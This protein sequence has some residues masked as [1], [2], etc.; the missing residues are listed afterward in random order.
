MYNTNVTQ[1]YIFRLY[2]TIRIWIWTILFIFSTGQCAC[3]EDLIS[4]SFPSAIKHNNVQWI[5]AWLTN[6]NNN[7]NQT[8]LDGNTVLHW[9][10]ESGHVEIV[11]ILLDAPELNVNAQNKDGKTPLHIAIQDS[12]STIKVINQT[13]HNYFKEV[14]DDYDIPYMKVIQELLRH[15]DI[16]VN[17]KDKD[18]NTPLHMSVQNNHRLYR[19]YYIEDYIKV[20]EGLLKHK[21]INVNEK[22]KNGNTPLHIAVETGNTAVIQVLIN[23]KKADVNKKNTNGDTAL[24]MTAEK[25]HGQDRRPDIVKALCKDPNIRIDERNQYGYTASDI[26]RKIGDTYMADLLQEKPIRG[27]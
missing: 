7:V 9:A 25:W 14:E 5:K 23:S 11:K 1:R 12:I 13:K 16:N 3:E 6:P 21:D 8:Y 20:I 22:D 10:V 18:G 2:N 19:I 17:E 15:K 26:A 24:H 27:L 4:Y